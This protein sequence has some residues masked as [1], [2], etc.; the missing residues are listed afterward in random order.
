MGGRLRITGAYV[1]SNITTI[2]WIL[3]LLAATVAI[4]VYVVREYKTSQAAR[5]TPDVEQS[6]IANAKSEGGDAKRE[7]SDPKHANKE[8]AVTGAQLKAGGE[9]RIIERTLKEGGNTMAKGFGIAALVL[10][11]LAIFIP[12]YGLWISAIASVFAVISALA[13]DRI[14][15]TAAP[16]ITAINL[17]F[18]SPAFW[19]LMNNS[20]DKTVNYVIVCVLVGVPFVAMYLNQSGT[21]KIANKA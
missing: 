10:A 6:V 7:Y 4:V 9:D 3:L 14:F 1:T 15:A 20:S 11:I 21:F 17:L 16:I 5:P 13:G 19:R 2:A 18:L 12:L 8:A